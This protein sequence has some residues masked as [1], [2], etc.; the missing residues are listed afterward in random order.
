MKHLHMTLSRN[1]SPDLRVVKP[2]KPSRSLYY[3][4]VRAEYNDIAIQTILN[5]QSQSCYFYK[6]TAAKVIWALLDD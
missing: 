1:K 3:I 6:T 5:R 2:I 4:V